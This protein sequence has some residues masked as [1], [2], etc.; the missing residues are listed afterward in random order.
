MYL[1]PAALFLAGA[2]EN[3]PIAGSQLFSTSRYDTGHRSKKT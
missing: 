2:A 3:M 1:A